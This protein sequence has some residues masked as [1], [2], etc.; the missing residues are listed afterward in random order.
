MLETELPD[1]V[2]DWNAQ[3]GDLTW[4]TVDWMTHQSSLN[5][6]RARIDADARCRAVIALEDPGVYN[7]LDPGGNRQRAIML[8]WTEASSGPPP[9]LRT[10]RLDSL[11][12]A[13]P[14]DTPMV[15]AMEWEKSLRQRRTAFQMRRRW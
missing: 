7:W 5:G 3:L 6:E 11:C 10:V 15:D 12:D 14:R 4:S 13:L 1:R 2:R 8:R 9:S